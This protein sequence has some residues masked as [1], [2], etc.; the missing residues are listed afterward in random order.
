MKLDY[1]SNLIKTFITKCPEVNRIYLNEYFKL[2][3][4]NIEAKHKKDKSRPGAFDWH[5][6]V[7]RSMGGDKSPI[8]E[9]AMRDMLKHPN[10]TED[11]K[12][13]IRDHFDS[14]GA[15]HEI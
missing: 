10:A 5:H 4:H 1:E 8:S 13:A 6:I 9:T 14:Y 12:K 15:R 2:I 11:Q 3:E 7:P